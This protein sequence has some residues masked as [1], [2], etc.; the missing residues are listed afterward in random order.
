M[1]DIKQSS[2]ETNEQLA[3]ICRHLASMARSLEA[4]EQ[5]FSSIDGSSTAAAA[6]F[7]PDRCRY[8]AGGE[9]VDLSRTEAVILDR[10]IRSNGNPVSIDDLCE[11][12]ELDPAT[13]R[14]NIKT[15]V[16][17]LRAKLASLSN[18]EFDIQAIRDAG[19]CASRVSEV[20]KAA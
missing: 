5:R 14:V 4:L 6:E 2:L 3:E 16:F 1:V 9:H 15:Y 11:L 10:L 17:R 12:L 18:P 20:R 7:K 13:Q 8:E 19:Y